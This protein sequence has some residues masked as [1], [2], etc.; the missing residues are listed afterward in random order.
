MA[1][2]KQNQVKEVILT[3]ALLYWRKHPDEFCEEICDIRLNLYQKAVVR[4]FFKY[5]FLALVWC[6][7][8]GKSWLGSLCLVLFCILYPQ[9]KCGIIAPSYRQAKNV[10]DEKIIREIMEWSQFISGEISDAKATNLKARIEFYN[11]SWIE[12]YPLGVDGAKIRG[13]RLHV[14]LIDE[15]AYVPKYIIEAVVKPMML[16]KRG[17]EVGSTRE[18]DISEGNKVLITSTA[19][20]RFN[21]LYQLFMDF[22]QRMKDPANDKYFALSLPYQVGID[23]GLYDEEIIKQQK[24]SMSEEQFEMEYLGRFPRIVEG[25]W[26][27]Y[28]DLEKCSTMEHIETERVGKF[29]YI[30]SVDV[31]RVE[32]QDNTVFMVWK[33]HWTKSNP[34]VDLMY[35]KT[36]NGVKFSDQMIE[37]RGLLKKF[38]GITR[39]YMDTMTIGKAL[40]DEL[41][42]DYYDIDDQKWYP[43]LIDM[44]DEQAMAVK[45][46]TNGIPIIYGITANGET[47]HFFGMAAKVFTQKGNVHFYSERA[48]ELEDISLEKQILLAET[49]E[50]KREIMNMIAKPNG[51]YYKF[52][53]NSKRKDRWTAFCMGLRGVQILQKEREEDTEW[54]YCEISFSARS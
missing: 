21:H 13:A 33:I 39:I 43:P 18:E 20:Y 35:I 37:L 49:R 45:E 19:N 23:V 28:E 6:R 50:T 52:V 5:K 42:K 38:T 29:E 11:G 3:E 34:E 36:L 54:E 22:I 53:T 7:G 16:V 1:I 51:Q 47:N 26:I 8:L 10:I 30:A 15:C 12:G 14:V 27:S 44:N 32:G 4:A 31:A 25:A 17:Y 2:S 46:K 24:E 48:D 41:A 9:T 40:A